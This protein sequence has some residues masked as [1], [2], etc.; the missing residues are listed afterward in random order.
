MQASEMQIN[1]DYLVTSSQDSLIKTGDKIRV[2][3][4]GDIFEKSGKY[5]IS[6]ELIEAHL[7]TVE[8]E[9]LVLSSTNSI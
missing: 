1:N 8:V 5:I 9:P 7:H 6:I 4:N 2:L 3:Q